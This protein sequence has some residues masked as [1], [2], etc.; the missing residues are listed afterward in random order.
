MHYFLFFILFLILAAGSSGSS[1]SGQANRVRQTAAPDSAEKTAA[2]AAPSPGSTEA[3]MTAEKLYEAAE[4]YTR[5]KVAEFQAKKIPYSNAL[6]KQTQIE[7]KQLAAKY[8][9]MLAGSKICRMKIFIFG[10]CSTG[11]RKTRKAPP[12]ICKSF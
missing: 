5:T 1:I 4:S 6:Y 11:W 2:I 8:A 12:K 3:E 9:A 7:Q 10:E